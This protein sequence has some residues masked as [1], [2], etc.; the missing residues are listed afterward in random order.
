MGMWVK[1]ALPFERFWCIVKEVRVDGALVVEVDNHL[2][3][4][5]YR[6][7]DKLVLHAHHVLETA[8]LRDALS[9]RSL[10]AAVGPVDAVEAWRRARVGAAGGAA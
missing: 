4:S 3:R 6:R 8:D 1:V 10:M 9:F 5:P 7:G 2:I